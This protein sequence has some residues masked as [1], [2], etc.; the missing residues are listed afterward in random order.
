MKREVEVERAARDAAAGGLGG[1]P[2]DRLLGARH[3]HRL[4]RVDRAD[5]ERR[6]ELGDQLAR[7]RRA[8]LQRRHAAVAAGPLLVP[9]ARDDDPCGLGQR[10]RASAP[11]RGDLADAVADMAG[12][13]NPEPAQHADDAELDRK[14][15][16]LG[17]VGVDQL[18]GLDA[19]LDHRRDRP[20]ERRRERPVDLG[21]RRAKRRVGV[22]GVAPHRRELRAVAGKDKGELAL[23]R[24]GA[25]E[26]RRVVGAG[27]K[28]VERSD[29]RGRVVGQRD[30]ALQVVVAAPR[31]G[32]Q[33][34]RGA[35]RRRRRE[36][37]APALRQFAQ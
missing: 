30:Q 3:G 11:R 20:A 9:A 37:A 13:D 4:R 36:C 8:K 29:G 31:A 32:A 21:D 34:C 18:L 6:A 16:R 27:D 22:I 14:Q 17:D 5:F 26:D 19:A 25:G 2:R 15:E 24:G 23:A 35:V 1:Q 7:R 28:I 10:Q 12:G 33:Q